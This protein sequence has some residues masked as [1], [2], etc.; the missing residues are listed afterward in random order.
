MTPQEKGWKNLAQTVVKTAQDLAEEART[1]LGR[2]L[3]KAE[4][5]TIVVLCI[6][7]LQTAL[8]LT[9]KGGN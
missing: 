5:H 9:S 1:R 8:A 7:Q 6:R 3:T 2:P 4:E